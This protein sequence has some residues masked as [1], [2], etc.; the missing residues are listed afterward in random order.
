MHGE[1]TRYL[2]LHE[3]SKQN[4]KNK[5]KTTKREVSHILGS[6]TMQFFV[7]Y[8]SN[9]WAATLVFVNFTCL[10]Y[11]QNVTE[12]TA[13]IETTTILLLNISRYVDRDEVKTIK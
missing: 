4:R 6:K 11:S 9:C 13:T 12:T 7:P 10:L 1:A 2:L 5:D 3:G 8:K